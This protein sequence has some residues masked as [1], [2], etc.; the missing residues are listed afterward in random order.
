MCIIVAK[1]MGQKM[2]G[3]NTI[4][5]C[6]QNNPDGAG[7][8]LAYKGQVFG[9][10][11]LMT[12][13]AFRDKLHQL[14]KRFGNLKNFAVVMHFRITTHGGTRP[15]NTHPFPLKTSYPA[16]RDLEWVAEQGIAH[17]GIIDC[18]SYHADIKAENVSDTMVF[19]KN[20]AA[21]IAKHVD[22][23]TNKGV[24]KAL[25]VA[26]G[27]RLAFLN[28]QGKL[29]VVGDFTQEDGIY[30]S[31]STYKEAR[32]KYNLA[33]Y[34]PYYTSW[35]DWDDVKYDTSTGKYTYTYDD[36]LDEFKMELADNMELFVL[37][38][39]YYIS[40][41]GMTKGYQASEDYALGLNDGC[42]YYYTYRGENWYKY[43]RH[44]QFRLYDAEGNEVW[45]NA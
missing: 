12:L 2:P 16:L 28:G 10:K 6:F 18:T 26:A 19:I 22:I 21:P 38:E 42:L 4:E 30:Y 8:M 23:A 32:V 29:M 25:Q 9:F 40:E 41:N 36:D 43:Y 31:N 14:E 34:K 20:V 1:P 33:S 45:P 39:S 13:E 27:S 24:A 37:D 17:N 15:E 35:Y 7:I 44:N 5:T 11:G 3:K